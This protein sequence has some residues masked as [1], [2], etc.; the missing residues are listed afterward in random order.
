MLKKG[1][2]WPESQA[3]ELISVYNFNALKRC[4]N[5][6]KY[7][8]TLQKPNK[9]ITDIPFIKI[10]GENEFK[11]LIKCPPMHIFFVSKSM[12]NFIIENKYTIYFIDVILNKWLNSHWPSL[13]TVKNT[14]YSRLKCEITKI[15]RQKILHP[16][17]LKSETW[18][19]VLTRTDS[20]MLSIWI[21]QAMEKI[22]CQ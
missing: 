21:N 8:W 9:H 1:Q 5:P 3:G 16:R 12:L 10:V 13:V 22:I 20:L 7:I 18:N 17:S 19:S 2:I 4:T 11:I 15:A 6:F 14:H